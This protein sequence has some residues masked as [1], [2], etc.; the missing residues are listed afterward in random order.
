[1]R[2]GTTAEQNQEGKGF[3]VTR[4]ETISDGTINP[5]KVRHVELSTQ[6]AKRWLL[7]DGDILMSHINSVEHIGKTAIYNINQNPLIHGMN[8]LLIRPDKKQVI[9]EYMHFCLR[10]EEIRT[11]IRAKCKRAINQASINQKELGAIKL[12]TPSL[13]EQRR[14]V[15]ILTRAE[16]IVRLRREALKK[17]QEIIPAL[18]VDMFGDPATNPKGWPSSRLASLVSFVSG[19]TPTKSREDYWQGSIPWVSPKDMKVSEIFDSLDHVN[20]S[21]L[22]ETNLKLIPIGAILVVVRGMILAHTVPIAEAAIPLVINQD[23]KALIPSAKVNSTFVAWAF[24]VCQDHLLGMVET[25]AHGTKKLETRRLEDFQF[26][27]PPLELQA[28]FASRI[29]EIRSIQSQATRA[30]ATAEATFQS[31]LHRA[32]AGEL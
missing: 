21:A 18:F 13:D 14:L 24:K 12:P 15:D 28:N 8:L 22:S 4:I 7:E 26:P 32:F 2:N 1:M 25:A 5:K 29:S 23:I 16:S 19:G 20:E 10:G 9:P 17:A 27:V 30:L 6:D 3:P 11:H 31:L